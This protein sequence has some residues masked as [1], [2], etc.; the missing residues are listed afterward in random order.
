M[1]NSFR[2]LQ[3]WNAVVTPTTTRSAT[4]INLQITSAIWPR[5]AFE[6]HQQCVELKA[7][8]MCTKN[9]GI[10]MKI[11]E[12]IQEQQQKT[13]VM[14]EKMLLV[15]WVW[16]GKNN[17]T[18]LQMYVEIVCEWCASWLSIRRSKWMVCMRN[19]LCNVLSNGTARWWRHNFC[20]LRENE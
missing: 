11:Y 19:A 10:T 5:L 18:T 3:G 4:S 7:Q 1:L 13:D 15:Q 2:C 17:S 14:D 16:M 8:A 20:T 6:L 12:M 9:N